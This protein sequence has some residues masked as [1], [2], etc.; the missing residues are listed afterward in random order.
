MD[1]IVKAVLKKWPNVPHCYGW[2]AL[3]ARGNWRMRD[4]RCQ[5]QHLRGDVIRH[6]ALIDFIN[7]NYQVDAD[8]CWYFQNGPQRVYVNLE[9][10]PYIVRTTSTTVEHAGTRLMFHTGEALTQ[11]THFYVNQAGSFMLVG[12]GRLAQIDDRDLAHCLRN[13]RLNGAAASEEIL[14]DA[15]YAPGNETDDQ[16][17]PP[18][19]ELTLHIDAGKYLTA[20][21]QRKELITLMQEYGYQANPHVV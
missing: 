13:L 18:S 16:S 17:A 19:L 5:Q 12:D 21:L 1:D 15:I 20:P 6:P 8:G 4:E 10:T 11:I 14:F 3:D 2:L 7:R 9:S